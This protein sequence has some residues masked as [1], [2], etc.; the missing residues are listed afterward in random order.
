MSSTRPAGFATHGIHYSCASP[1]ARHPSYSYSYRPMGQ[2]PR[3]TFVTFPLHKEALQTAKLGIDYPLVF[4]HT[5]A[6]AP[7]GKEG[8]EKLLS[9][10][11]TPSH[12]D[13]AMELLL[14]DARLREQ[15]GWDWATHGYGQTAFLLVQ[16]GREWRLVGR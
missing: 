8:W 16:V 13:R 10:L 14:A 7:A 9:R 1:W 2:E 11:Q 12:A 6:A 4:C 3:H 5:T 15:S